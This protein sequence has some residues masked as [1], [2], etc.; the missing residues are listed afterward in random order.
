MVPPHHSSRTHQR[1][2]RHWHRWST[3]VPSY[4]PRDVVANIRRLMAGEKQEPML[5]WWRG[6]KGT[7]KKTGEHKYDVTG[8]ACKI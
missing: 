7:I 8:I 2:G 6:F 1:R 4:N 3:S 5:P